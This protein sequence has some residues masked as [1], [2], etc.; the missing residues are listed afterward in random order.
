MHSDMKKEVPILKILQ[1]NGMC[2]YNPH[3]KSVLYLNYSQVQITSSLTE[4]VRYS[5]YYVYAWGWGEVV[6]TD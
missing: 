3:A 4:G 6:K 1:R 5:Q 2:L